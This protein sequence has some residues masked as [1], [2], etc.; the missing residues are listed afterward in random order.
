ME[1]GYFQKINNGELNIYRND[2]IIRLKGINM[3]LV[4][5]HITFEF[6]IKNFNILI[7][8]NLNSLKKLIA[9]NHTKEKSHLKNFS[10]LSQVVFSK[11]SI[12]GLEEQ[13]EDTILLIATLIEDILSF[14]GTNESI[15]ELI[16]A[17][18]SIE[19]SK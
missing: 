11:L 2:K 5:E 3:D 1:I 14:F 19:I 6:E 16:F 18:D 10:E 15:N 8:S 12:G 17:N 9:Q 13:S 7:K 4:T